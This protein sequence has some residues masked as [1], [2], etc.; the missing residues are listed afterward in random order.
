MAN[1]APVSKRLAIP[2]LGVAV[3]LLGAYPAT[4]TKM[5]RWALGICVLRVINRSE[6]P[7]TEVIVRWQDAE[8][9]LTLVREQNLGALKPGEG[10]EAWI[11]TRSLTSK[12]VFFFFG[13]KARQEPCVEWVYA[14]S[15]A[16]IEVDPGGW[17]RSRMS[18]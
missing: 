12:E 10:A 2:I 7:V 15:I 13:G 14:G 4:H 6:T 1:P 5:G 9:T 16:E 18:H 3:V 8:S 11:W 17:A